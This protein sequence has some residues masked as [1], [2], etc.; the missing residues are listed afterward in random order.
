M[1][2]DEGEKFYMEYWQFEGPLEQ[3]RLQDAPSQALRG[4]N[5]L[6]GS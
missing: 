3:S 6:G 4:R 1:S 5:E 2:H